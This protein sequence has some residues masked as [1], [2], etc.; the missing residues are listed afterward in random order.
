MSKKVGRLTQVLILIGISSLLLFIGKDKM[1]NTEEEMSRMIAREEKT[2][3][4][5]E[6][7]KMMEKKDITTVWEN[8]MD[9]STINDWGL[10]LS[11]DFSWGASG[12]GAKRHAIYGDF[13]KTTKE[14]ED[15]YFNLHEKIFGK[16]PELANYT[17]WEEENKGYEYKMEWAEIMDE[18]IVD[19]STDLSQIVS[20]ERDEYLSG[21][22]KRRWY[23]NG[24]K[25]L[26]M[27]KSDIN[28]KNLVL[29]TIP[30]QDALL[31]WRTI[32]DKILQENFAQYYQTY[33]IMPVWEVDIEGEVM[34]VVNGREEE[35]DGIDVYSV[36]SSKTE[37]ICELPV[38]L[39]EAR[40]PIQI[41]QI[42]GDTREGWIVYSYGYETFRVKYPEGDIEKLGNYMFSV[43]YSPDNKYLVYC[44]GNQAMWDSWVIWAGTD[45]NMIE[46]YVVPMKE[47]W[48]EIPQGWYVI[49][50]ENN[51]KRYIPIPYWEYDRDRP[52]IGG[53]CTWIEKDK[54]FEILEMKEGN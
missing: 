22:G 54:L 31:E 37:L 53:R 30:Y 24:R 46:K 13:T 17:D 9:L 35:A 21:N 39:D 20:W 38:I 25:I 43:S 16:K 5:I 15:I 18:H 51:D 50:L 8:S 1:V 7:I 52:L 41:W 28:E 11:T 4:E 47:K 14:A 23:E 2:Q 40:W 3:Q 48:G 12:T 6:P 32:I 29:D 45:V 26:E 44:T 36:N 19:C 33:S 42:E 27:E 49:D 10:F 34:A